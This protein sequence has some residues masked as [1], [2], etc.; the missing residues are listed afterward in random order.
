MAAALLVAGVTACSDLTGN[1][2]RA[3]GVYYLQSVNNASIPFTYTDNTTGH[4]LT[5]TNDVYA[6]NSDGTYSDQQLYTDNGSNRSY[7]ESGTWNQSNNVVTFYPTQSSTG[8]L[9][10]Y[11]ATVGNSNV[12]GGAKTM[13]INFTGTTWFY[14]E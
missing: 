8:N 1:N 12:F 10:V 6:V 2:A 7:T 14:S 5:V 9:T 11:T 13:S 3:D 4:S